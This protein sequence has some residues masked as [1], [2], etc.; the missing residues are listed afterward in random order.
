[1]LNE[2]SKQKNQDK[3]SSQSYKI[4]KAGAETLMKYSSEITRSIIE[5]ASAI[6]DHRNSDEIDTAD[7]ALILGEGFLL[8]YSPLPNLSISISTAKR[9]GIELLGYN[10]VKSLHQTNWKNSFP[11][12]TKSLDFGP[13]VGGEPKPAP[14]AKRKYNKSEKAASTKQAKDNPP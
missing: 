5:A 14:V 9:F 1:M 13:A 2:L 4:E 12:S 6:A 3:D 8:P 7:V 11:Q 10:R